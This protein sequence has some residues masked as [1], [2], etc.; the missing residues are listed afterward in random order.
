[1]LITKYC[2]SCNKES[3]F[4]KNKNSGKIRMHCISCCS[5]FTTDE[6]KINETQNIFKMI[7][8]T[9]ELNAKK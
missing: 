5:N 7:I 6:R 2:F 3:V 4:Y 9:K 8:N 1:M